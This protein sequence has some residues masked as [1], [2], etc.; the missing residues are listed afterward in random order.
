LAAPLEQLAAASLAIGGG[1][2][3]TRVPDCGIAEIDRMAAT[4]HTMA[5]RLGGLLERERQFTANASHQ[6]R[7]PLAGLQLGLEAA[8]TDPGADLPAALD[9]AL[10]TARRLQTTVEDVLAL[11]RAGSGA[12]PDGT[13]P[14]TIPPWTSPTGERPQ[15][16]DQVLD[17][18]A[19]RWHG[20]FAARGR[21]LS[22]DCEDQVTGRPLPSARVGQILDVLL[23]NASRHGSGEVRLSARAAGPATAIAVSDEGPG[24]DESLGDVFGRGEGAGNG[25]GLS[26][27]REFAGSLGGRLVLSVRTPPTFTLL[28]PN[29]DGPASP[30]N[31]FDAPDGAQRAG[32]TA[33]IRDTEK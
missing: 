12:G 6:L 5:D 8:R 31:R 24:I 23:D 7:T 17:E 27:A 20:T 11:H 4:Q 18:V 33:W 21:V 16:L 26:L 2:F 15:R 32:P 29:P 13:S 28:L 9:E 3:G 25:I 10:G 14:G 1:A 22:H 30:V 19:A